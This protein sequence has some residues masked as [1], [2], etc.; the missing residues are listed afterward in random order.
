[1]SGRVA[2]DTSIMEGRHLRAGAATLFTDIQHPVTV[3][4]RIL[5]HAPHTFLGGLAVNAFAGQH[6]I[7]T[8]QPAGR[9]V[10]PEACAALEAFRRDGEQF[11]VGAGTVGAVAIDRAGNV[12]AATSTGGLTGKWVGRIGDTPL[13]GAGTYADN[14]SGG[15]IEY[16]LGRGDN[17]VQCGGAD[18]AAH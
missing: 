3:A 5:E 10:S 12:A 18:W 2:T 4:R 11:G 7:E 13:L 15:G 6:G 16:G 9:L 8:M 17:A 1:M 14:A